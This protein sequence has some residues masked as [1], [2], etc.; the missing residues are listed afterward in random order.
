MTKQRPAISVMM[1][2]FNNAAYVEQAI[3]SVLT[4]KIDLSMELVIVDDASTDDSR[5]RIKRIADPRIRLIESSQNQGIAIVRNRL[6]EEARGEFLTSLDGDD[7]YLDNA[8]LMR[9]WELLQ[10]CPDPLSTVVYSDVLWIDGD[11]ETMLQASSIAPA[12]EGILYQ[13]ILDRRVMIP[14]DFLV[15]SRLARSVGGFDASLPIYEDWDYK[16]RLSQQASFR[17][18]RHI[19]IGYRR[20]GSGLSAASAPLHREC[21][22][23]I[24]TKHG[25]H[26]CEGDPMN[27]LGLASRIQGILTRNRLQTGKAA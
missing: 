2:C 22:A 23:R 20:H 12:M 1:P 17:F 10:S 4:Q 13:A 25:A 3:Q 11:G 19:G 21:Q 5:E 6:L 18:T 24:R 16:L 15:S 9:E 8:K 26:G 7:L 27:V 14:R